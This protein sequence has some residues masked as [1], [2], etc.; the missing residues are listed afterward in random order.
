MIATIL[1]GSADFHAVGYNERK[2]SK[3]VATLI[4][5]KN[6]GDIGQTNRPTTEELTEFL[7][8]Y[9]SSNQRIRK[10]QFH[11]AISCKGHELTEAELL[12]FAHRYLH[13][14]GYDQPGHPL[15]VYA[16]HDTVNAH[17]HL[18]TSRVAPDGRKID[19]S[20]ERRRS[21]QVID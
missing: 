7:L 20:H 12:D 10:P 16:H 11:V 17:L 5:I 15:L 9:S 14:M 21:Q 8:D 2:V 18:I 1:P 13:E 3:G 19:H 6:F 4:E